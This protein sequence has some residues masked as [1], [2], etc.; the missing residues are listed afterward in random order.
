MGGGER[1]EERGQ[2]VPITEQNTC[3]YKDHCW[4]KR[5]RSLKLPKVVSG[6]SSRVGT[7]G[8]LPS[9]FGLTIPLSLLS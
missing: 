5:F 2:C 3:T 6:R 1:E 8:D 9:P 7:V 4:I